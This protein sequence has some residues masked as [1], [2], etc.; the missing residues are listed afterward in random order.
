LLPSRK[1]TSI[2]VF[3]GYEDPTF[4]LLQSVRFGNS[5][6]NDTPINTI[7]KMMAMAATASSFK[8]LQ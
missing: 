3:H 5:N 2:P 6:N 1:S 8:C 4:H 7:N